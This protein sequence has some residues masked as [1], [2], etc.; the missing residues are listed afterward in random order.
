MWWGARLLADPSALRQ[1]ARR[2]CKKS[3]S[4]AKSV[5]RNRHLTE[6]CQTY[7]TKLVEHQILGGNL[8]L[9]ASI[10]S[11]SPKL[12]RLKICIFDHILNG[13]DVVASAAPV[14]SAASHCLK[15][16][17]NVAF[18]FYNFC[19]FYLLLT[20]LVTLFDR[21]FL[22]LLESSRMVTYCLTSITSLTRQ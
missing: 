16:T 10:E 15:I 7:L 19:I 6:F 14:L 1:S 5:S 11:R 9:Q 2:V 12:D 4:S 13:L 22:L 18:E 3:W 17:K 8:V 20:C 21:K